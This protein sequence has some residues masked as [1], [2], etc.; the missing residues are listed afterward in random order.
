MSDDNRPTMD[1]LRLAGI[2]AHI[3]GLQAQ[4]DALLA[5]LA[6]TRRGRMVLRLKPLV[7]A[8][9][10]VATWVIVRWRRRVDR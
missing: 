3:E 1:D 7:E 4:L 6:K 8:Y 10:T 5:E 2:R 9:A